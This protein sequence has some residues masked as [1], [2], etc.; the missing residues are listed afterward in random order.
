MK[1]RS[2]A[3]DE[4]APMRVHTAVILAAGHGTRFLPA[5]KAIPKEMLPLIDRPI[6]QYVVEE[7]VAA[8]IDHIVMVTSA[9]KRAIEDH[10]DRAPVVEAALAAKG[11]EARLDELTRLVGLA[12]MSFVRQKEQL[13]VGHAVL[14]AR[15]VVGREPFLLAF[16]DDI[17]ESEVPAARQLMD[18]YERHGSVVAVEQVPRE[19]IPSYGIVSGEQIEENVYK[20]DRLVEKPRIEDAPSDLGIVGRY[21][22]SPDVFDILETTKPG[23][24]GEIQVTDALAELARRGAMYA[25]RFQGQR[26]DTGRPLGLLKASIEIGLRRP[27]IGPELRAF[28]RS[29]PLD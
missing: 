19:D 16:P 9:G 12:H 2:R 24:G 14:Q 4:Q 28:L 13:G 29:L 17:I 18:V 27:D 21:V 10:F 1:P 22:L 5:T 7:A 3:E 20:L 6:V 11:D 25:C 23:A 15:R 26:F 8:G